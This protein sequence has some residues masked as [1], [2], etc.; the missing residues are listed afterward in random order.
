ME[1]K[2]SFTKMSVDEFETWISNSRIART[3]LYIQ[4]HHTYSPDYKLFNGSNH[5]ELQRGMKNH[6]VN[7]NG[8]Q[9]IG[10]HF[11]IFPD[12]S[13]MT[14]RS[15]ESSPAGI[16]GNN[17]NAICIENFGNFDTGRDIMTG[18]QEDAI[19]RIT[20]ALCRKFNIP[21]NT[22]RIVYHHWFNL[23][24]GERNNGTGGNKSCP[25]SN[26]FGGNK[27]EHCRSRFLPLIEQKMHSGTV[28]PPPVTLKYVS[29]TATKLN[30]RK[31]PGTGFSM[32]SDREPAALGAV[33]R[34][35]GIKDGWYKISDSKDHWIS[36]KYTIDVERVTV[37][38]DALNVRNQPSKDGLKLGSFRKG[39]EL[40][41][42]Q[43]RNGWSK[44]SFEEKWVKSDY[45]I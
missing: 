45:L 37:N 14:G 43:V 44:I 9:D 25:G 15:L 1:T 30:I 29:V 35:Y 7:N 38:A 23:V 13:V 27:V 10:H 3:I 21:R 28:S 32:V 6:H 33:L 31:G 5:F 22:D 36:G 26:F 2:Y 4:Q 40:F 16:F 42:Y 8:W 24:T 17:S 20:A 12:G 34:V 18:E 39:Q 41:V 11:T 19:I